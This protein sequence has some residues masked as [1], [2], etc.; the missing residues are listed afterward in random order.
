MYR[1]HFIKY[2][3]T[4]TV[5]VKTLKGY[6]FG[7]S[8]LTRKL[9]HCYKHPIY[10]SLCTGL[11]LLSDLQQMMQE[12]VKMQEFEHPRVMSLIGVCLESGV[13]I[14]MPYMANGSVLNYLK[15]EKATLLLDD[16]ANLEMVG[17]ANHASFHAICYVVNVVNIMCVYLTFQPNVFY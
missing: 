8:Y 7:F 16:E 17:Y 15:R 3:R 2:G 5:A 13:G 14:V 11:F 9:F 6:L 1:A 12:V 4:Y 10:K